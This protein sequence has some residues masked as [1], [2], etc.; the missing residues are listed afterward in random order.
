ML[1]KKAYEIF[2]GASSGDSIVFAPFANLHR[3]TQ[4]RW[5]AVEAALA[6][7]KTRKKVTRKKAK[8]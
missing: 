2:K 5:A 1:G 6:P 3:S 8:K 7:A 4:A